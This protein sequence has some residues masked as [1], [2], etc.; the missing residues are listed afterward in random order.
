VIEP[1]DCLT[2]ISNR[3]E[4][5]L[6]DIS[7]WMRSNLLKLNQDK[8][9]LIIFAP[10]NHVRDFENC[11]LSF[12]GT[13]VSDVSSV[14]NLGVIFDKTL[15]MEKQVSTITKS[16]FFHIRN[17]GRIRSYITKDACKTLVNSL[18]TSRL[19]Y[20]NAML[21][22]LPANLTNKLQRVQN[23]AARIISRAKKQDHITPTLVTLHWL[24]VNYRCQYKILVY[25]FNCLHGNAPTYLKDLIHFYQPTRSLRSENCALLVQPRVRTKTYGERRFDKSAA[26]LWNNLPGHLRNAKSI[27]AFKKFLKT[28]LFRIAFQDSF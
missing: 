7:D 15:T 4:A 8:T 16:C 1:R 20:G 12:D 9:E 3:I 28:H 17:I 24:P 5:C 19:D 18:V 11:H 22:G 2:D 14:R 6:D 27:C 13:V 25:V 21:Y 10:K 26:T 23:T